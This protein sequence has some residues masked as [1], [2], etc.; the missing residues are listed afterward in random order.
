[1]TT[2]DSDILANLAHKGREA[3]KTLDPGSA[4]DIFRDIIEID[5][6]YVDG[7]VGLAQVLYE[8]GKLTDSLKALD[9][10]LKLLKQKRFKTWPPSRKLDWEKETDKPTLRLVHQYGLIYYRKGDVIQAKKYFELAAKLDPK[11][12]A[13]QS[14][15]Q[16]IAK[17][18][19]YKELKSQPISI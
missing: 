11:H 19:K 8:I 13:P 4:Q 2:K 1:M 12:I 17:D 10:G 6:A 5:E 16:D 7:W 3:L 14:M 15:L 18:K 9:K